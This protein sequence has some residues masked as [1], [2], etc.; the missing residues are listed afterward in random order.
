MVGGRPYEGKSRVDYDKSVLDSVKNGPMRRQWLVNQLCPSIMSEKK[1]DKTLKE[2]VDDG[3]LFKKSRALESRGG[4]ETWYMLPKH[5]LPFEVDDSRIATAIERLKP[6]LL[7]VPT[8]VELAVEVGI[9][10]AEAENLAYKLASKTDWYNPSEKLI[11]NSKVKLG[12]VLVCAARI[13]DKQVDMNGGSK[14]F[15]YEEDDRI[16]EEAKRFLKDQPKL[17]PTLSNDGENVIE[18]PSESLRYLGDNYIPKDRPIQF[19]IA[20]NRGTGER[21]L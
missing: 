9:T 6:L 8:I 10:P 15:D 16:V 7:R 19:V 5:K 20:F 13:R 21:I 12:E 14:F 18:W 17:L 4:W 11:E 1:L 2:L 3:K